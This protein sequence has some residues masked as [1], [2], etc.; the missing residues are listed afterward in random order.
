MI[1][2][3][4][5]P[6]DITV[7]VWKW[8]KRNKYWFPLKNPENN[9]VVEIAKWLKCD[10]RD[11]LLTETPIGNDLMWLAIT[12]GLNNVD[13]ELIVELLLDESVGN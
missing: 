7:L 2:I 1:N 3:S 8:T 11:N 13:W 12:H 4:R 9:T 6:N 5:F 10:V